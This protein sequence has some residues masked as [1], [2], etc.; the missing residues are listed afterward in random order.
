MQEFLDQASHNWNFHEAICDQYPTSFYDWKITLLFYTAIHYLKALA[1]QKG[2]HIG[3]TH[4]EIDQSVNPDRPHTKMPISR[5]AWREYK[6]LYNYSR[7]ARYEGITDV[8]TFETLKEQDHKFCLK[9]LS[10]FK[11]YIAGQGIPIE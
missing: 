6:S 10:N 11:K 4:L 5:N 1:A 7:S 9:H 2:I 8:V 3:D